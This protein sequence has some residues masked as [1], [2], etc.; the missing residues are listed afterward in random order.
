[1]QALAAM[2]SGNNATAANQVTGNLTQAM[3]Q[4]ASMN[5]PTPAVQ[6]MMKTAKKIMITV[7]KAGKALEQNCAGA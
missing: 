7:A 4:L 2:S 1:M 6:S 3:N 5:S